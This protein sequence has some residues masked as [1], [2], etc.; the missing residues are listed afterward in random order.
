MDQNDVNQSNRGFLR[1]Q[2]VQKGVI[3]EIYFWHAEKN[4]SYLQV[5]H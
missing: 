1:T 3:K 5:D 4:G 2:Y